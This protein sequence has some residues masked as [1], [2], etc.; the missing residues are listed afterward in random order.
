MRIKHILGNGTLVFAAIA[1]HVQYSAAKPLQPADPGK[2]AAK[3][4]QPE[5]KIGAPVSVEL[6]S[7]ATTGKNVTLPVQL[8]F[9]TGQPNTTL[10]VEYRGN[11]GL[12][13]VTLGTATL[14]SNQQGIVTDTP[15]VRAAADGVYDLNVFVTIGERTRAVSIP[16]TVGNAKPVKKAAGKAMRTPQGENLTIMPAQESH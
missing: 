10:Q 8:Q 15:N 6:I 9:K 2:A 7:G 16:V 1:G 12:S 5:G 3:S 14:V 4:Q 11:D 13:L